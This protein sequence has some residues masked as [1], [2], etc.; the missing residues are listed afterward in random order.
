MVNQASAATLATKLHSPSLRADAVT[1]ARIIQRLDNGAREGRTLTLVSAPAGFGKTTLISAWLQYSERTAAWFSLDTGDNDPVRFWRYVIAA[2][3]THAAAVGATAVAMLAAP[4]TPLES[5]AAV[6]L[7]DLATLDQ[8]LV[9]VIDDYHTITDPN[10]HTS[11]DFFLD[12]LPQQV[13]VVVATRE[14]PPLSLPRRRARQKLTEIRAIDLRFTLAE[15][16]ELLNA[17]MR[18]GLSANDLAALEQR[19]EGWAVGLQLAALSLQGRSDK[20]DFVAAFAGDDRFIADYLIEE[21]IQRQPPQVQDFLLKTSILP[22]LNAALCDAVLDRHDSRSVLLDLERANLFVVLLDN[23]REWFRY[24]RLF[25]DLLQ[26]RLSEALEPAAV[27]DLRHRTGAWFEDQGLLGEAIEQAISAHDY[28]TAARRLQP[29]L[30]WLFRHSEL[31]T[32]ADYVAAFPADYLARHPS[33]LAMR[34]WALLATGQAAKALAC[35][36]AI[37][38]TAQVVSD[39]FARWEQ[40]TAEAR[41][42]LIETSVMRM[43]LVIDQGDVERTL[44]LAQQLWPRLSDSQQTWLY[45]F[46]YAL[47][48]PVLFM[49]GLAHEGR[50]DVRLAVTGFRAA[51][52]QD[53][54]N[55]HI[56]AQALGHLGQ[57]QALQGELRAATET[58][59][60]AIQSSEKLGAYATPFFGI[61]QAGYGNVL[62]ELNNLDAA[63]RVL[64]TAI[65]QGQAWH[66]WEVLIP[67]YTGLVR[68]KQAQGDWPAAQ[69]ALDDLLAASQNFTRTAQPLVEAWRAWLAI[70]Q[71]RLDAAQRWARALTLTPDSEVTHLNEHN[72]IIFACLLIAQEQFAAADRLTARLLVSTQHG[73]RGQRTLEVWVLRA[74]V[75]DAQKQAAEASQALSQALKLAEPQGA[76]RVFVEAGPSMARLLRQKLTNA[77]GSTQQYLGGMLAAVAPATAGR[78]AASTAAAAPSALFEPLSDREVEVLRLIDQGLSNPEIA[79]KLV[80]SI[81]T[82][83]VHTHN[84]FG[85]LTVTSRTQAVNKARALG[86]LA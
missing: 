41:A 30:Q 54:D 11:L 24:H 21:V 49:Q 15:T 20:H 66:S 44:W 84:I 25:A 16:T 62:Y 27:I 38:Q 51:M 61:S 85:K 48:A 8:P 67:A 33:L 34:S 36:E 2:L 45:N 47:R 5:L 26:Q 19:T 31:Q 7:N 73:G 52:E 55:P 43:R 9:L 6:L 17:K 23:R 57:V 68:V 75:L 76:V 80:L 29:H 53:S 12:H 63:E 59:Q 78:T 10:I 86:L 81:G 74:V 13:H 3:Q 65:K 42:A 40:L 1:R 18:L 28:D 22:R 70:R 82:V 77:P 46:S 56:V 35:I 60:Q 72:L 64:Q 37:E 83:K 4:Q 79:A 39:D 14:D 58:F 71:G 50:G 69:A 32:L